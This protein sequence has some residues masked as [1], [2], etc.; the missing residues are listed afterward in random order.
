MKKIVRLLFIFVLGIAFTTISAQKYYRSNPGGFSSNWN[1]ASNWDDS[2][3]GVTW[4]S[5]A[6]ASPSLATDIVEIR[7]G[8][9]ITLNASVSV[10]NLT[11]NGSL[12]NPSSTLNGIY[13]YGDLTCNGTIGS[14]TDNIA[15]SLD[16]S[17]GTIGGTGAIYLQYLTVINAGADNAYTLDADMTLV[18]GSNP[19]ENLTAYTLTFT[20]GTGTLRIP[21]ATSLT[22]ASN[23]TFAFNAGSTIYYSKSGNQNI[24]AGTYN[25]TLALTGSGTKTLS[26]STTVSGTLSLQGTATLG[27]GSNLSSVATLEYAGSGAQ[28]FSSEEWSATPTNVTINNANG[29][30]AN[31]NK[32]IGGTLTVNAG[33][34]FNNGTYTFAAANITNNGSISGTG[35]ISFTGALAGSGTF[36]N[37]ATNGACS[38]TG[39]PT[40]NQYF[41]IQSGSTF[42]NSGGTMIF[43]DGVSII[44]SGGSWSS[45]NAGVRTYYGTVDVT[46]ETSSGTTTGAELP[47]SSSSALNDL[48][49]DVATTLGA[50]ATVNG[51]VTLNTTLTVNAGATLTIKNP[52]AGSLANFSCS[53]HLY[54]DG[55]AKA[56]VYIPAISYGE[57]TIDRSGGVYLSGNT[58]ITKLNF[59]NGNLY[60]ESYALTLAS[61]FTVTGEADGSYLVGTLKTT[62]ADNPAYDAFASLGLTIG[63]SGTISGTGVVLTRTTGSGA[64]VTVSGNSGFDRLY[65]LTGTGLGHTS[66]V[67]CNWFGSESSGRNLSNVA[68]W[69]YTDG[70]G[71]WTSM[72]P[73]AAATGSYTTTS[74]TAS[75]ISGASTIKYT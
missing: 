8:H 43:A 30:A 12:V 44:R 29:V 56:S 34:D 42:D 63:S 26:G 72:G 4:S 57:V 22:T 9:T 67:T 51:T 2:N 36:E 17:S 23:I 27:S 73:D 33:S 54:V 38:N 15:I 59:S 45:A 37:L 70:T 10:N 39:S 24:W 65:T 11:I 40:I 75:N 50:S 32:A 21:N 7:A 69:E 41:G 18:R 47:S 19:F 68:I 3:D 35:L 71:S 16:G 61:G 58:T 25:G 52:F 31:G 1:V 5:P 14:E 64:S 53:G 48:T 66:T 13:L 60:T 62:S 20:V 6:S 46:Y 74:S 55:A 28:T 49:V